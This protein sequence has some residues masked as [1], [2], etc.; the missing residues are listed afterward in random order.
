MKKIILLVLAVFTVVSAGCS[1]KERL[2]PPNELPMYGGQTVPSNDLAADTKTNE[3][4][5]Q[6]T[7]SNEAAV[8]KIIENAWANHQIGYFELAMHDFNRAWL[9]DPQNPEIFYGFAQVLAAQN[10]DED[11]IHI[12]QKV[13]DMKPDHGLTLC[14]MAR[15]YQ[16]KAVKKSTEP[17]PND[18]EEAGTKIEAE[19]LRDFNQALTLYEKA[20]QNATL[21]EHLSFIYYQWAI[22][23]AVS[24]DY[25][26]AWEKVHLSKKHGGQYIQEEFI[27]ALSKD[28][29]EPAPQS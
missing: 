20:V 13:L 9:V 17:Y 26:G 22:A 8:K 7:G 24:K 4:M 3:R 11:A 27:E 12:Y 23:L 6:K 16:N 25:A 10:K 28:M 2:P 29:P 14:H 5:I 1:R 19:A 18:N 15:L 21:D